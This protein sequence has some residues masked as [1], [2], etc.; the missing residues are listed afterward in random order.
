[1][2]NFDIT[3]DPAK[4][5]VASYTTF[6]G[7]DIKAAFGNVEVGNLQGLSVSVNREVRPIFV[8][9]NEDAVSF[10]RGKRGIAGSIILNTFDR[11]ALGHILTEEAWIHDKKHNDLGT[12]R[13][14]VLN[15]SNLT[16]EQ[17]ENATATSD[18]AIQFEQLGNQ[19][20]KRPEYA[21]ELPPFEITLVAR[22]SFG[23]GMYMTIHNVILISEGTGVSVDDATQESQLT[24]VATGVTWWKALTT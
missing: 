16:D 10:S 20:T 1:M 6:A 19:S 13:S 18:L 3:S 4:G 5:A 14:A 21:D 2:S 12:D 15:A 22:N 11:H 24:F 17:L 7:S 8:M 9:G 23:H